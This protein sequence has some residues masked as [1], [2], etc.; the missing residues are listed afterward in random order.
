MF[1][2]GDHKWNS[3]RGF[4]QMFELSTRNILRYHANTPMPVIGGVSPKEL[5]ILHS[6]ET[7]TLREFVSVC[8]EL[9]VCARVCCFLCV[10]VI[11]GLY[12]RRSLA[13]CIALRQQLCAYS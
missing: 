10:S 11:V 2:P 4:A 1:C 7:A 3:K 9:C 6:V 5:D 12:L 8:V 13:C